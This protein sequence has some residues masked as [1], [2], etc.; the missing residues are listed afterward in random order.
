MRKINLIVLVIVALWLV[1]CQETEKE[2]GTS[3]DSVSQ[4][5]SQDNTWRN[6][7]LFSMF[8]NR[9]QAPTPATSGITS[10]NSNS[11]HRGVRLAPK[12]D[13]EKKPISKKP[14]TYYQGVKPAPKSN[15]VTRPVKKRPVRRPTRRLRMRRF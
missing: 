10:G 12:F 4:E 14:S 3:K 9:N 1:G 7:W 13:S 11:Y 2:W 8:M 6:L 15:K 5:K